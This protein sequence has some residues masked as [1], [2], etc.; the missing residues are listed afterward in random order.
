MIANQNFTRAA[1]IYDPARGVFATLLEDG[2]LLIAGGLGGR[3]SVRTT[4]LYQPASRRF[5]AGPQ[6]LAARSKHGAALLADGSVL[7]IGGAADYTWRERLASAERHDPRA[8]RF[9]PAGAMH[10]K[11]FKVRDAMVRL[12]SGGVLIAG[13]YDSVDP[14]PATETAQRYRT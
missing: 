4:E 3:V 5:V 6:M 9:V 12:P 7:I 1:E 13:G 2:R 10:A 11:R 8:N 14:L